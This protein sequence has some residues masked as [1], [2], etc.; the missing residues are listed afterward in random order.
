M[1]N[2]ARQTGRDIPFFSISTGK[3]RRYFAWENFAMPFE[4]TAGFFQAKRLLKKIR[5][6]AVMSKG[7]FVSVPVVLAAASLDIPVVLHESDVTPGLS[8]RICA[9]FAKI[10]C[11]SW[12]ETEKFFP[13]YKVVLTGIPVREEILHGSRER[14]LE[15][16][17]FAGKKPVLLV[18]GGSLG[19]QFLNHLTAKI[20]PK[21]LRSYDV[22]HVTGKSS[23]GLFSP[24]LTSGLA[25]RGYR[26]FEYLHEELADIYALADV[27]LSRAGG[28]TLA[29]LGVLRKPSVLIPLGTEGSRGDQ[30]VNA[31]QF[32]KMGAAIVVAQQKA[33]P[34]KLEGILT[35][36]A[37]NEQKRRAMGQHAFEF[38]TRCLRA[39]NVIAELLVNVK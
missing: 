17:G 13:Q 10:I 3:L 15:I 5:P 29:D 7:G 39:G 22:V 34:G 19:A 26:C 38:G 4:V 33:T 31:E 18:V 32:E 35:D 23:G 2:F 24:T 36:L 11:V 21:L 20:L 12:P 1:E 9:K 6:Q 8:N 37:G 28:G 25:T 14:G 16:T 30:I 27:V